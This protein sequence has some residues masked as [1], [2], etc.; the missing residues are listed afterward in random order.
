MRELIEK[1]LDELTEEQMKYI[2][3]ILDNMT[4]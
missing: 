2:L 3:L 1:K 4:E